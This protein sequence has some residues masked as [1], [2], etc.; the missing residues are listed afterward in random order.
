MQQIAGK[1]TERIDSIDVLRGF[2]LLGIILAIEP[3][4]AIN[5]VDS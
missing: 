1:K 5:P 3:P 4:P 2:T